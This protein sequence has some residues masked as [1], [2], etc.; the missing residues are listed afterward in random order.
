MAHCTHRGDPFSKKLDEI[1]AAIAG[2]VA[3]RDEL[4]EMMP[5]DYDSCGEGEAYGRL[6]EKSERVYHAVAGLK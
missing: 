6:G 5:D 3:E 1:D 4:F 2:L